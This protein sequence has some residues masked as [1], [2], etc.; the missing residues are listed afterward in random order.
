MAEDKNTGLGT[1]VW[2]RQVTAANPC[3]LN[4]T[5]INGGLYSKLGCAYSVVP[6]GIN[7]STVEEDQCL[8]GAEVAVQ[9]WA[10]GQIYNP[11][12]VVRDAAGKDWIV[13]ANTGAPTAGDD[14]D[15]GG[16]PSSDT[17]G[18]TYAEYTS[19]ALQDPSAKLGKK[20]AD[21]IEVVRNFSPGGVE[22]ERLRA[23]AKAGTLIQVILQYKPQLIETSPG[24]METKV[25][26]DTFCG[27]IQ[28]SKPDA[29]DATTFM[30]ANYSILRDGDFRTFLV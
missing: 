23:W 5:T 16:S 9:T 7:W 21:I 4:I 28:T 19:A 15:L 18:H 27:R 10:T 6:P 22:T 20:E 14:S 3:D 17:S 2:A 13:T 24:N 30:R 12:T 1:V 29:V 8:D 11:G 25:A 26:H